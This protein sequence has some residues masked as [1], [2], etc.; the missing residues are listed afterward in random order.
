MRLYSI[1]M[2]ISIYLMRNESSFRHILYSSAGQIVGL[3][4][5]RSWV[6]SPPWIYLKNNRHCGRVVK[7]TNY[8]YVGVIP[9][10]LEY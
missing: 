5:P 4:N 10:R 9:R 3:L 6:R 8:K 2:S 7:A 1:F